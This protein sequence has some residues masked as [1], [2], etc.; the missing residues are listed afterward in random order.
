MEDG[1]PRAPVLQRTAHETVKMG[2]DHIKKGGIPEKNFYH[3]YYATLVMFQMQS[4]YWQA[5][6]T[7]VSRRR[8]TITKLDAAASNPVKA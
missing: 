6:K 2:A 3:L 8:S 7:R 5:W 1:D 4:E